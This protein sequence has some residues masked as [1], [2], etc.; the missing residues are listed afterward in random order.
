MTQTNDIDVSV[1]IPVYGVEKYIERCARSLFEQTLADGIEFIFINDCTPDRSIDILNQVLGRYPHRKHQTRIIRHEQNRGL[2]ACR[3][4]GMAAARGEYVIHCDSDDW[5]APDM[6]R[7]LLDK[8]REEQVDIVVC[9][10]YSAF[11][12]RELAIRQS[13]LD[14]AFDFRCRLLECKLHNAV[15]NKLVRRNLYARLDF[16]WTP[17]LNM[18]EDVSVI[19][20]LAYHASKVAFVNE[21]LYYYNQTNVASYT[22][23]FS[24]QNISQIDRAYQIVN[25]FYR[26][27]PNCELYAW[28]LARFRQ[29]SLLAILRRLPGS[30]RA[31]WIERYDDGTLPDPSY[32][33]TFSQI[34]YRLYLS[35]HNRLADF[36]TRVI[37]TVRGFTN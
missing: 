28:S 31:E 13:P 1:L 24:A 26:S 27:R 5:V 16:L 33:R 6:Y 30:Q 15:W 20:R 21:P 18:W 36:L 29:I 4:T 8:A 14:S 7:K 19:N 32:M 11:P 22:K 3:N 25:E 12:K 34:R 17:G 35:G 10:F 23:I 9:D 37:A 2:A